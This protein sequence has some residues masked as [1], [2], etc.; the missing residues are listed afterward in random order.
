MTNLKCLSWHIRI[1]VY[2][3]AAWKNQLLLLKFLIF[4]LS[5]FGAV[6]VSKLFIENFLNKMSFTRKIIS[7]PSLNM[8]LSFSMFP[9]FY[10][11]RRNEMWSL[12]LPQFNLDQ[13]AFCRNEFVYRNL[14]VKSCTRSLA[15][16][17]IKCSYWDG[18]VRLYNAAMRN[19]LKN[20]SSYAAHHLQHLTE[21]RS[22]LLKL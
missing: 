15:H 16:A 8:N 14:S 20:C 11:S 18:A 17:S 2:W 13:T 3:R 9:N 4:C 6:F 5:V 7:Y 10:L 19:S 21:S 1:F 22:S 12:F